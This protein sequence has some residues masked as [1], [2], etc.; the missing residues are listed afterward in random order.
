M[1]GYIS[2]DPSQVHTYREYGEDHELMEALDNY[3]SMQCFAAENRFVDIST[4]EYVS[5]EQIFANT[6][7]WFQNYMLTDETRNGKWIGFIEFYN[8]YLKDMAHY[9]NDL[10]AFKTLLYFFED[11]RMKNNIQYACLKSA[12]YIAMNTILNIYEEMPANIPEFNLERLKSAFASYVDECN[13]SIRFPEMRRQFWLQMESILE[14]APEL[15]EYYAKTM[16]EYV[17]NAEYKKEMYIKTYLDDKYFAHQVS[18]EEVIDNIRRCEEEYLRALGPE[19]VILDGNI[20][21][22]KEDYHPLMK[23]S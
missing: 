21:D 15:K 7:C 22:R 11:N 16:E 12:V 18:Y 6:N 17:K 5:E 10:A 13:S 19:W 8:P 14:N 2:I 1:V 4:N 3:Y 20:L 23:V 9:Y